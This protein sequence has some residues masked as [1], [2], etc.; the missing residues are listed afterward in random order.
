MTS[1][2]SILETAGINHAALA[3][4]VKEHRRLTGAGLATA[5]HYSV[6]TL[7]CALEQLASRLAGIAADA[8]RHLGDYY[9]DDMARDIVDS[10]NE[11]GK[12]PLEAVRTHL[13]LDGSQ[14]LLPATPVFGHPELR[15]VNHMV[16]DYARGTFTLTSYLV[17]VQT[18][19]VTPAPGGPAVAEAANA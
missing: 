1:V 10:V 13:G 4:Q 19:D 6:E 5:G 17:D 9:L 15:C 12:D 7:A 2:S 8:S 3:A 18:G 11:S 16:P 14:P